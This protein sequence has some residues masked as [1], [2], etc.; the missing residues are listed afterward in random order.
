MGRKKL[1]DNHSHEREC[2]LIRVKIK[3]IYSLRHPVKD[4]I[5]KRFPEMAEMKFTDATL[6]HLVITYA[7]GDWE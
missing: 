5:T 7:L 6:F 2:T 1:I 3:D 4:L